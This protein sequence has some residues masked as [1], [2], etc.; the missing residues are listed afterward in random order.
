MEQQRKYQL[1]EANKVE[2]RNI[3]KLEKQLNLAKR[4][5]KSVPKAFVV[6]GLD[7]IL[8]VC[9][10]EKIKAAAAT[11][12]NLYESGSEFE[13]DLAMVTG[14]KAES[15]IVPKGEDS[16]NEGSEDDFE[17]DED[18]IEDDLSDI[19]ETYRDS[20]QED[21]DGGQDESESSGSDGD[22]EEEH[23]SSRVGGKSAAFDDTREDQ[24]APESNRGSDADEG[25]WEDIYGRKRDRHGNVVQDRCQ[26]YVPPNLRQ[27][28]SGGGSQQR[29]ELSRLRKQMKGLLNRLAENNMHS[30]AN[31]MEGLYMRNSRND[32]N[33]TLTALYFESL[34]SNTP[35][36]ER[37][38]MEHAML[39]A[40]LHANV[41]MEIGAHLLQNVVKKFDQLTKE[42]QRIENKVIDNVL[43]I[44]VH[45]YTFRVFSCNLIYD[46]MNRLCDKFGEKEIEL[47]ILV[48]RSAG[49][50]LRKD[51][52]VALKD[53]IL[54]AQKLANEATPLK[55]SSRVRFMVDILMTIKNNNMAKLP[56]Y[57]PTLS[58][59]LKK[60]MKTMVRT[61]NSVTELKISLDDL[62]KVDERG[63][64]WVVGSAWTGDNPSSTSSAITSGGLP[65]SVGQ[66]TQEILELARKQRMN[67]T[68]RRNIFCILM[69]AEDY[70]DAFEK[71]LKLGLKG[72][73]EQEIIHVLVHCLLQET[74][75]NLYYVHIASQLCASDRR[76]QMTI[77]CCAWDK[78]KEIGEMTDGQIANL[79]KFLAHL[80][81]NGSL[82]ISVLKVIQFTDLDK[83]GVRFVRQVLL[84]MLLS[85]RG[86][87]EVVAVFSRIARA[88]KLA[89]FREALRL[90]VHHF[91]A[92]SLKKKGEEAEGDVGKLTERIA[93]ADQVLASN[94]KLI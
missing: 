59:H 90:F 27:S 63:R 88:D 2:D 19:S 77:Q 57:D 11:E 1:I 12:Q 47:I 62:L 83:R 44:I 79:A 84:C 20:T 33:E 81:L 78:F 15:K 18:S 38:V 66:V 16:D 26:K 67:T 6:S 52:P 92:R 82:P 21:L 35:T 37:L 69:T 56:Q 80:F 54:R 89:E 4:K 85:E 25:Y 9:D 55:D 40:I 49:F 73:P 29:E 76:H 43:L 60:L 23:R 42:D 14:K 5:A 50:S 87:E 31:Q 10:S 64:W 39:I 36:P 75:F 22:E 68:N 17:G 86:D 72:Q 41:G 71:L 58:N 74:T 13:D 53:L 24:E 70:L 61:G 28:A 3:R 30:I 7:Y 48:L 46:I 34:V 51:D 8:D 94:S 65:A 45:L 93:L 32:T 91:V